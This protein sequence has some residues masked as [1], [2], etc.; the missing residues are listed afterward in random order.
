VES[1]FKCKTSQWKE[2]VDK[3]NHNFEESLNR[4]DEMRISAVEEHGFL[5]VKELG[6]NVVVKVWINLGRRFFILLYSGTT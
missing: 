3:N 4:I 6:R 1:G 5:S 2:V